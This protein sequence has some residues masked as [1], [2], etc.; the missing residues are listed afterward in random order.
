M[1]HAMALNVNRNFKEKI[2]I[3]GLTKGCD[4]LSPVTEITDPG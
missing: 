3:T 2:A 4:I 1:I